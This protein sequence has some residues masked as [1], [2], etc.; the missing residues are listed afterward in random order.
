MC[1]VKSSV[2]RPK[3]SG[4]GPKVSVLMPAFNEERYIAQS[5][6][7]VLY[8]RTNFP[9]ELIIV[10][11]A[12]TDGTLEIA[13]SYEKI[14][15]NVT[16]LANDHN[17]GKGTSIHRAYSAARGTY[18]QV[19]DADD[20]F[21]SWDKLQRQ[22]DFLDKMRSY[23][24]VAHNTAMIS[25]D[26][27]VSFISREVVERDYD[28]EQC[29]SNVFY[30]HTSAYLFRRI[31]AG[32]PDVFC[33]DAMRGDSVFFYFHAFHFG[34]KVKYFPEPMSIYNF[35]GSGLWSGLSQAERD[36]KNVEVVEAI[37]DLVVAD[38][39]LPEFDKLRDRIERIKEGQGKTVVG[40]GSSTLDELVVFWENQTAKIF[41]PEVREP[42]FKGMYSLRIADAMAEL[43]GRIIM[44][45]TG[46]RILDRTYK[47]DTV[48][49][50]VSGFVPGGG[51]IFR[52]IK[53]L[54][55][56]LLAA[57]L[58][59]DIISSGK[60]K[61]DDSI[62]EEHFSDPRISYFKADAG[63]SPVARITSLIEAVDR[64]AASR[65]FPFIT[66]HDIVLSAALQRGLGQE[67]VMDFVYDHGLS[68]AVH[69]SSIDAFAIKTVSQAA[70]LAP[71]IGRRD[72]RLVPPF[73]TDAFGANPYHLLTNGTDEETPQ[74][75]RRLTTASAAARSYKVESEYQYSYFDIIPMIL[76]VTK[77]RHYHYG[78]LSDE[79]L[80]RIK[81]IL[82]DRSLRAEQ[83]VHIPWADDFGG[84]ILE[85][86]VDLFISPFPVCSARI[87]VEVMSCGIPSINHNVRDPRMP[88]AIDFVDPEQWTWN[89]PEELV[90]MVRTMDIPALVGK[91]RS[92][93]AFFESRNT[94]EV[95]ADLILSG[96]G[97]PFSAPGKPEYILEDIVAAGL[98]PVDWGNI[99]LSTTNGTSSVALASA[100]SAVFPESTTSFASPHGEVPGCAH[101][102]PKTKFWLRTP[103]RRRTRALWHRLTR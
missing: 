97:L 49:L 57:N 63:L 8:Q 100:P 20:I 10:D 73:I 28:Y 101:R 3:D 7:S 96:R 22:A 90:E 86:G 89:T 80:S 50:L 21:V 13:R 88:Q 4:V 40:Q 93:R 25:E 42:A 35:H 94:I 76:E 9:V 55:G 59:I 81:Q 24:A 1:P 29:I 52:E 91:S 47:Q 75:G 15:P 103:L 56:I 66:H 37:R 33:Q 69:N 84:S 71:V 48:V 54:V 27:R 18:V 43:I 51:G 14:F 45:Q 26:G 64:S 38:P 30:F 95:A 61:T 41:R 19:L 65:I 6:E 5:I 67:I 102:A 36:Q 87:A 68:L 16:V 39:D 46:R 58:R 85:N 60:I 53:E 62:I 79:A 32:L 70:A 99:N 23:F 98:L 44:F 74:T 78:P 34:K 77:G 92:A 82:K 72:Y 31:E 83:F 2:P 12:S 17:S 11:D